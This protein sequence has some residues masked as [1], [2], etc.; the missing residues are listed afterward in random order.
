VIDLERTVRETMLTSSRAGLPV[1]QTGAYIWETFLT[2]EVSACA[3]SLS[4]CYGP[5]GG[6]GLDEG[7]GPNP[8]RSTG[9]LEIWPY[10]A[11]QMRAREPDLIA[12]IDG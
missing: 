9:S 2:A 12:T 11:A 6:T 1:E 3:A 8:A 5:G 7:P 10:R 4:V